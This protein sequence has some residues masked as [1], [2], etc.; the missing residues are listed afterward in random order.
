[1]T[2]RGAQPL[3]L[4]R[5]MYRRRRLIDAAR[6]LPFAGMVL[7]AVAMFWTPS[8]QP[9]AA[10][11]R[12]GLYLFGV[13]GLLIIGAWALARR[14][15]R[16]APGAAIGRDSD[17]GAARGPGGG[18]ADAPDAADAPD[19]APD[20]SDEARYR[21]DAGA[22]IPDARRDTGSPGARGRG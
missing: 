17:R 7:F 6:L 21:S 10:T 12:Q 2:E 3:Y 14:L 22:P 4:A 16:D 20:G 18:G 8:V 19:H 9:E 15:G 11:A 5:R 13:W 1:M